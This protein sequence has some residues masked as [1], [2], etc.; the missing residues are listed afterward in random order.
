MLFCK[1]IAMT[2]NSKQ[3]DVA[4]KY[5]GTG[6][7][8]GPRDR[9][10]ISYTALLAHYLVIEFKLFVQII[11]FHSQKAKGPHVSDVD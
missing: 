6:Q 9:R 8:A 11:Y 1:R 4:R 2:E 10:H 3:I 5:R 7:K